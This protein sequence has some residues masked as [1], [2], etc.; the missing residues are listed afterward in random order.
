MWSQESGSV[1]LNAAAGNALYAAIQ[2]LSPRDDTQRSLKAQAANLAVDL[3]QI[4][5]LLHA[6]SLASISR[7][8]LVVLVLWLAIIF[9]SFTLLAP[10]NAT[11]TL[12]LL[13]SALAVAGAIFLILEMDHPFSGLV[14]ISNEPM[15]N[16]LSQ[17]AP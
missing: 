13:V 3:A 16:A 8:L 12:A 15:L 4:R 9:F 17:L 11:A 7:P 2:G 14:Q 5:T 10:P 6:Q 1:A